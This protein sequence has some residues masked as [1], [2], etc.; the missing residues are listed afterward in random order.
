M[1]P[2]VTRLNGSIGPTPPPASKK[3]A[4]AGR[5]LLWARL[6]TPVDWR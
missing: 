4:K 2:H 3:T 5:L 6:L 1:G